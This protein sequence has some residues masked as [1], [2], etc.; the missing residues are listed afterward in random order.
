MFISKSILYFDESYFD[1]IGT[2]LFLPLSL[3][4]IAPEYGIDNFGVGKNCAGPTTF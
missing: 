1:F 4:E 2:Y 3:P